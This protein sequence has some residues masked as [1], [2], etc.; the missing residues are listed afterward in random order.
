MKLA[1]FDIDGTLVAGPSTEKRFFLWLL[2]RGAVGPLRLLAFLAFNV[3]WAHRYGRHVAKKNKAYLT[4]MDTDRLDAEARAFVAAEVVPALFAPALFRL[5]QHQRQGHRVVLLSGTLQPIAEAL[6]QYLGA[7]EAV[8]SLC[9]ERA[10]RV[11]WR[12]PI[13]HPFAAEK[14][15]WLDR[16]CDEAGTTPGETAAYGDSVHDVAL[17][18]QV[19]QPVA[20]RPDK[21]LLRV[22]LERDWEVLPEIAPGALGGTR[23]DPV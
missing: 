9:S 17:L 10:G 11:R 7:D 18:E 12:P 3:F 13:R 16:L 23:H 19:A 20:V 22:A 6:R 1:I 15:D 4:R 21:G 2:R 14:R 5:R 8:G